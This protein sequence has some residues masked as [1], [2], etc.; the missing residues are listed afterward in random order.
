M[1]LDLINLRKAFGEESRIQMRIMW[2]NIVP[3]NTA[4]VF[5]QE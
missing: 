3:S 2:D 1:T 5:I 4:R